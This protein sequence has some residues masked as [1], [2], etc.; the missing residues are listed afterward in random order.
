MDVCRIDP[1]SHR[2]CRSDYAH[3]SPLG[4]VPSPP[5]PQAWNQPGPNPTG[6]WRSAYAFWWPQWKASN[7]GPLPA[8]ADVIGWSSLKAGPEALDG[9]TYLYRQTLNVSPPIPGMVVRSARLTM[10]SDNKSE[11]FWEGRSIAAD[12][13][14]SVGFVELLP[15]GIDP[16][17]GQYLL[18]VQCS[19]DTSCYGGI[20]PQGIAWSLRVEWVPA[21][22]ANYYGQLPPQAD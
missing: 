21:A 4:P 11:W 7:W 9:A 19:N 1:Y 22:V 5:A 14:G 12:R 3:L 8:G 20:N 6:S 15:D 17:G 18:A 10:W 2:A 16:L 13:Q